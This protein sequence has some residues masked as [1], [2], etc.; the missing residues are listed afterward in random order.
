MSMRIGVKSRKEE[1][2]KTPRNFFLIENPF[3]KIRKT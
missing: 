1:T 3:K 2:T